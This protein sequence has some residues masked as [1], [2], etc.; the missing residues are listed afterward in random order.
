[1]MQKA[2]QILENPEK[3]KLPPTK[4]QN[5]CKPGVDSGDPLSKRGSGGIKKYVWI[6]NL[7]EFPG[8]S[9]Y[10]FCIHKET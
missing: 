3:I 6:H 2:Q 4:K 9:N 5:Q 8:N 10:S 7:P 1:M